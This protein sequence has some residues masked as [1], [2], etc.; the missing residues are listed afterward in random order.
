M[1]KTIPSKAGFPQL[2]ESILQFWED[3]QIFLKS[4]EE[5]PE[6][7][8]YFFYDGP[9]FATGLPHYGHLLASTIKDV[10]PRYQTMLG[11]RVE[12]RFGW[13]CHGL[14]VEFEVEKEL[15]LKGK[16]DIEEFGVGEFNE[17][18]RK[19]VLRYSQEWQRTIRR[20]GRWVDMDKDYKTMDLSFMES[21]WWVFKTLWDKKLIYESKKIVAYSPRLGTPLS[22]F[23]V[24]L[25]YRDTQDPSITIKFKQ[26]GTDNQYFLAWT[27]T[28]WTL[29]SNLGLTVHPNLTY[30]KVRLDESVYIL[31]EDLLREVFPKEDIEVMEK[32]KGAQLEGI[33]YEPLFPYFADLSSQ[34]AFRVFLGDYVT[35]DTGTGIVHTA[36]SFGEDDFITGEKYKLPHVFPLDDNGFFTQEAPDLKGMFFKDADKAVIRMLKETK[37]LVKNETI[38]HSYP[39]CW[40]S[41]YPLMYRT[42]RSWFLDVEAIKEVMLKNN[43]EIHWSPAHIKNGRMGK[44]LEGAKA[45]AISRNRY[46]GNPIPVWIC[47]HCGHRHCIGSKQELEELSGETIEDLHL[48]FIDQLKIVCPGCSSEMKRT[49]EV[50]DCWFESGSMPYGQQHY[51]FENKEKFDQDFPADFISEGIDQTRGWFYTLLVLSAALFEKPAFKNCVV[52]G[53]LLAEDGKKMSKSL[54]N[55]PDPWDILNRYGADVVRLYMLNSGAIKAEELRFSEVGLKET[56]RNTMLPL[57]N[58]LIFFTTY[59]N[60]DNWEI[61]K[62]KNPESLKNP[63]DRWIISRLQHLILEVRTN[64]DL[65]DLNRSVSPFV[66]FIDYLTNWYVRRSRR[67][68]WKGGE[69]EDKKQAYETL[70]TVLFELSKVM[71][72]FTPFLAENIYQILKKDEDPLSV[73]LCNYP[74]SM[75]NWIDRELERE[76]DLILRTVKMGR[77]LRAKHQI[78]IRQPL[79]KVV[80]L[81][82]DQ[83]VK[84]VLDNLSE[85]ITDELNVKRIEIAENEED[86]VHLTAK[87]NLRILG[88]KL[89]KKMGEARKIIERLAPE[90]IIRIQHGEKQ[91]IQL[92]DESIEIG[93]EEILIQRDQ[94]EDIFTESD[95]DLTVALDCHLDPALVNEGMSRE[96]VSKIQQTRKE[97]DFDVT[98]RIQIHFHCGQK[99]ME[100]LLSHRPYIEQETLADRLEFVE[101]RKESM[102]TWDINGNDCYIEVERVDNQS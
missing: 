3:N 39:F 4:I 35:V 62:L 94:K 7:N 72:P 56:L 96:F 44:W 59:A 63:L 24:N 37:L 18:C 41:D 70:F 32:M 21:I 77:A 65:Y 69:G 2:E 95:E 46:W 89:G 102:T 87:P 80:L 5:K 81:T 76:M 78:K 1:F 60:I 71:A 14:P 88:P 97:K 26:K 9:P 75:E 12:R 68:F 36:P 57:L 30:V 91:T 47:D 61:K 23:E 73:H 29:P 58:V 54:K 19:I 82:K 33:E 66:G 15:G 90:E 49:S 50:L 28:P 10:I 40:R 38:T 17:E 83:A 34:G 48:H 8:R 93:M 74:V 100:S 67:R 22:N 11:N 45:W 13:D 79:N 92:S 20:I 98:N 99:L 6:K 43:Q 86:L 84:G 101:S 55:Y 25:G 16:A 27:T 64:M 51:P 42:I 52:S 85:L 31:V 53:M